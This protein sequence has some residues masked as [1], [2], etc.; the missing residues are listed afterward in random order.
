[1][2]CR[3]GQGLASD[4]AGYCGSHATIHYR[5]HPDSPSLSRNGGGTPAMR[6]ESEA[7]HGAQTAPRAESVRQE[8]SASG[9]GPSFLSSGG[10]RQVTRSFSVTLA[11]RRA[12]ESPAEY[13]WEFAP[14]PKP[15]RTSTRVCGAHTVSG[16]RPAGGSKASAPPYA[17]PPRMRRTARRMSD[18][19]ATIIPPPTR[20]SCN[21]QRARPCARSWHQNRGRRQRPL[22]PRV[23]ARATARPPHGSGSCAASKKTPW[24]ASSSSP[25]QGISVPRL[26]SW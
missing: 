13:V 22:G 16:L 3:G 15:K 12:R 20:T 24:S 1:M 11:P 26:A 21:L 18:D 9:T 6:A 17:G 19:P 14:S 25:V 4:S 8:S 10:A 2:L 5:S 23:N 7:G